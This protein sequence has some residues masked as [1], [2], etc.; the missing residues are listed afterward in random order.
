MSPCTRQIMRITG[1]TLTEAFAG[2]TIILNLVNGLSIVSQF[3]KFS[4]GPHT[5]ILTFRLCCWKVEAGLCQIEDITGQRGPVLGSAPGRI[6][7][8][9]GVVTS[10]MAKSMNKQLR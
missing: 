8:S 5:C 9:V 1:Q 3:I 4:T 2:E 6:P 10:P 7:V